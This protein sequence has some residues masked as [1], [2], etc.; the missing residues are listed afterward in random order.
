MLHVAAKTDGQ[1]LRD[2][3]GND[4]DEAN[5][6]VVRDFLGTIL[7]GEKDNIC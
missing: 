7:L 3:L 4:I 6:M 2:E 5:G 1:D